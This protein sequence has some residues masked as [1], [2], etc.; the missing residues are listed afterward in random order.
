[1]LTVES[2]DTVAV[3][4]REVTDGQITPSSTSRELTTFDSPR[5]YPLSGPI[6]V[7]RARPGDRLAIEILD[8]TPGT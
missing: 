8:V 6:E 3:S 5:S 1:V 4:C 7:D 2:G